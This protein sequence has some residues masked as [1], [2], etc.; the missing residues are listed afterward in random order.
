MN[1]VRFSICMCSLFASAAYAD[2]PE[3]LYQTALA[4]EC[5]DGKLSNEEVVKRYQAAADRGHKEALGTL[6]WLSCET[7]IDEARTLTRDAA[8]AGSSIAE[9]LLGYERQIVASGRFSN[10]GEHFNKSMEGLERLAKEGNPRAYVCLGHI[11]RVGGPGQPAS[12]DRAA[13]LYKSAHDAGLPLGTCA[14]YKHRVRSKDPKSE[15]ETAIAALSPLGQRKSLCAQYELAQLYAQLADD[16]P[17][18]RH[19]LHRKSRVWYRKA[20]HQGCI[21]AMLRVAEQFENER[22]RLLYGLRHQ[23]SRAAKLYESAGKKGHHEA[24]NR[25]EILKYQENGLQELAEIYADP[26]FQDRLFRSQFGR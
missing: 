3:Q 16:T 11:Y 10:A 13:A 25:A 2:T 12:K 22:S 17:W 9:F 26:D 6:A 15:I 7:N 20:I 14:Y 19:Q 24:T 23:P 5:G 1:V 4:Y 21:N 8:A 18:D